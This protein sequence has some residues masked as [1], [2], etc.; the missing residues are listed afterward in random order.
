MASMSSPARQQL[1]FLELNEVNFDY[2]R[3]YIRAGKLP[4]FSRLLAAHGYVRTESEKQYE[5]L[6][7]WI[8]WVTAHTGRTF[9]EHGVFRLGDIV[10]HDIPQVWDVLEQNGVSVGAVSPMNAK[11]RL[12]RPAF[13]VPDPWTNTPISADPVLTRLHGAIAQAVNDNSTAR[14]TAASAFNLLR[15]FLAYS[16]SGNWSRYLSMLVTARRYPWRKAMFLDL[17]LADVFCRE[18]ARTRPDFSSLFLNAA[19]H[20]QH[21]YLFSSSV[22]E[23]ANANPDWYV[24]TGCDPVLEVY[25]LYDH[26]LSTVI[27]RTASARVMIGTALHQNP[28]E[29][30]TFYWRL[31]DHS[32]FLRLAGVQFVTVQPL[33]SRDFLVAFSDSASAARAEQILRSVSTNEGVALFQ[34]DNRGHDLFVEL[35]YARD[36]SPGQ[37]F[38]VGERSFQDLR[39]HVAFVAIKNGEHSGIGYFVDTGHNH[40]AGSETIPLSHIPSLICRALLGEDADWRALAAV[41]S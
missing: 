29:S 18:V 23:G 17:L 5:H 28:H 6:E 34:I 7:P 35:T 3:G 1:L 19:A 22:Y 21:H 20:I 16:K 4:T 37:G 39:S 15:G 27:R 12:R 40:V 8:Q 9:A 2:L 38:R 10:A 14:I 11:N 31:T 36:I 32:A 26:I 13:F 41:A 24:D 30:S 25:E 33:M